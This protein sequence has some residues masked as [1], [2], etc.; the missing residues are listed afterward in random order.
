MCMCARV[1]NQAI[2][3]SVYDELVQRCGKIGKGKYL[4]IAMMEEHFRSQLRDS[5][6]CGE[7][8]MGLNRR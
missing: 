5:G 4:T 3:Q 2:D 1:C 6:G 7:R 8:R